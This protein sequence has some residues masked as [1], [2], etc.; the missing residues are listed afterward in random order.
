[1]WKIVNGKLYL[2]STAERMPR[3]AQ[4]PE[5]IARAKQNWAKRK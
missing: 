5:T 1:V 2:F 4:A 3:D